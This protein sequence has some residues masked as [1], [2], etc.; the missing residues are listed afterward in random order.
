MIVQHATRGYALARDGLQSSLAAVRASVALAL[1]IACGL[2]ASY[3]P[4]A[5]A[6]ERK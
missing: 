5:I 4:A 2:F 1:A 3:H 6:A